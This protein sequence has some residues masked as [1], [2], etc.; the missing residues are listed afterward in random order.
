MCVCE[1]ER[2]LR[3]KRTDECWVLGGRSAH[4]AIRSLRLG[5]AR[6]ASGAAKPSCAM[7]TAFLKPRPLAESSGLCLLAVALDTRPAA[8][9]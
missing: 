9:G 4:L 2:P 8:R 5:R 3:I 1:R 7:K 6:T